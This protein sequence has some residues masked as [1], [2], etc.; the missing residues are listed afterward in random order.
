VVPLAVWPACQQTAQVQ[1]AGRYLPDSTAH[2]AKMLPDLARRIVDTYSQPGDLVVDP[3]CGIGTTVVEAATVGRRAV[4]VELEDRWAQIATA[5]CDHILTSDARPLAEIRVGDARHLP[6][7]LGD[8]A[9]KVD[10]IATSPPYACD[11]GT[12]DKTAWQGGASLCDASTLNYSASR[13]NVGHARGERY[14]EEMRAI[15]MAALQALRPGG[16]LVTV[17]KNLRRRARC[18]DLAAATV[19]LAEEVGFRYDQHIIALLC[20]V[21][22]DRLIARP[23]FWQIAQTRRA[24]AAGQPAHLVAHEDVLVFTAPGGVHA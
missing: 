14:L 1:R 19:S 7:L 22:D 23:S 16:R 13:A 21:R 8:L 12:I 24:R 10:L 20:A 5:N 9:G 2:P 6:D 11:V 15:Y 17:T 3:M 18:F 4:G